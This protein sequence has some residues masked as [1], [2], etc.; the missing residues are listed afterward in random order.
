[1]APFKLVLE[2]AVDDHPLI[3]VGIK[4]P[5][6]DLKQSIPCDPGNTI[7]CVPPETIVPLEVNGYGYDL[8]REYT[9]HHGPNLVSFPS[10][11]YIGISDGLPLNIQPYIRAV[12]GEGASGGA[13]GIGVGDKIICFENTWYSVISPEGCA[14]ILFRDAS[15]AEEAADSM[16][17]TAKDLKE[18]RRLELAT[19]IKILEL[20]VARLEKQ[21]TSAEKKLEDAEK[22]AKVA[23]ERVERAKRA[24]AQFPVPNPVVYPRSTGIYIGPY[25]RFPI[26]YDP[27][28]GTWRHYYQR[29]SAQIIIKR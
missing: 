11:N 15:R 28:S 2:A 24:A 23:E 29:A 12:I 20:K 18:F 16:M 14:S 6:Q 9:I 26:V 3:K 4:L 22:K 19:Q 17:V 5:I 25:G 21:A 1:M 7:D 27:V 13:L 10:K 8:S